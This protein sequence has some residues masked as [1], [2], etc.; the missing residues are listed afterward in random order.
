MQGGAAF[1]NL[2]QEFARA[3]FGGLRRPPQKGVGIQPPHL[4]YDV[5]VGN[6]HVDKL[7]GRHPRYMAVVRVAERLHGGAEIV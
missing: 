3:R 5:L 2:L 1:P 4:V 6:E 7:R